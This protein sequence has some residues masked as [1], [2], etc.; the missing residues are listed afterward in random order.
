MGI[1]MRLMSMNGELAG[2]GDRWREN[3]YSNFRHSV[4]SYLSLCN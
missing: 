1:A 3:V 2:V 4:E